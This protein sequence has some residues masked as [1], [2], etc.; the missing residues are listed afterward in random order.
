MLNSSRANFEKNGFYKI[1]SLLS[2]KVIKNIQKTIFDRGCL[3]L[4]K[5]DYIGF[6]DANFHSDLLELRKKNPEKFGSF[7]D[8]M[9]KSFSIYEI[10]TQ[11]KIIKKI[12]L[13]T[14][15]KTPTKFSF[16][17]ENIRMDAPLDKKNSLSWHQDSAYY[18][19]NLSGEEGLVCW[20]PLMNMSKSV[21]TL[22]LCK[23]SHKEGL[24][25]FQSKNKNKKF[26][27]IQYKISNQIINKYK[28]IQNNLLEGDVL[29]LK[30]NT[31]H[32]SGKNISHYFRFS[33][34]VRFHNIL[35]PNYLPFRS[36]T[37][38]NKYEYNRI[39]KEKGKSANHLRLK[40]Y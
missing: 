24:V 34:Q 1:K 21:G 40:D 36:I 13:L 3:Y 9:Q 31:I 25:K 7:Y 4:E 12:I 38:Y 2:K 20:I 6:Y 18:F 11:K 8:S 10:V 39:K 29:F 16:S 19:Q 33:L 28:I 35:D 5:Y 22:V 23:S 37:T 14:G 30:K 32:R 27:S 15:I 26:F 17:G